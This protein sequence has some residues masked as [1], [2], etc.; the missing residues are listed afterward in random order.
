MRF[1]TGEVLIWKPNDKTHRVWRVINLGR[2]SEGPEYLRCFV[3]AAPGEKE[4]LHGTYR[5]PV[6]E[7][8]SRSDFWRGGFR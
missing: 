8:R 7:L 2:T 6:H 1:K 3:I 4:Y 5:L